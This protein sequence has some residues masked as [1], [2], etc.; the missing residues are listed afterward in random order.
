VPPVLENTVCGDE[1]MGKLSC[2]V[3]K[4]DGASFSHDSPEPKVIV[5]KQREETTIVSD[6]YNEH[7]KE[8]GHR[9]ERMS[10]PFVRNLIS[11][12]VGKGNVVF[13]TDLHFNKLWASWNGLMKIYPTDIAER[14]DNYVIDVIHDVK[15]ILGYKVG[16]SDIIEP[17]LGRQNNLKSS[18]YP[19][20]W[21][22]GSYRRIIEDCLYDVNK[23]HD[24]WKFGH[25]EGF[26]KVRSRLTGRVE[27]V[28]VEW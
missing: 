12:S 5:I 18:D 23:L 3:I 20:V 15:S 17:T 25:V 11:S 27:E 10:L 26:I 22:Q 19:A 4:C 16:L 9:I 8:L 2:T 7:F 24:L 6:F 21:R 14:V 1:S 13:G 28:E